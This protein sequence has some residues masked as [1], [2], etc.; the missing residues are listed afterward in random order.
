MFSASAWKKINENALREYELRVELAK[1]LGVSADHPA[2]HN[3]VLIPVMSE[4]A[5]FENR[6]IREQIVRQC[7]ILH[8][9]GVGS[10]PHREEEVPVRL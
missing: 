9:M 5:K 4:A 2:L 3:V 6:K 10:I 7:E 8:R 1:K